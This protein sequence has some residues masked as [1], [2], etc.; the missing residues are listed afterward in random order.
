VKNVLLLALSLALAGG[1][2][3][4]AQAPAAVVEHV[5]GEFRYAIAP[6]PAFVVEH[7]IPDRWDPAVGAADDR[8]RNWLLDRQVDRRGADPVEYFASA[9]EATTTQF[10]DEAARYSIEF[11]PTYQTLQIHTLRVRRDGRWLD[12]LDPAQVSLARRE[13]D[14]ENDMS[15]GHVAALIVLPDVRPHDIVHLAYSIRGSNPIVGDQVAHS[16]PLAWSDPILDRHGRVL[17]APGTHVEVHRHDT[18]LEVA[19]R[20]SADGVEASFHLHGARAVRKADRLPSWYEPYPYVEIAASRRW[21]DVVAWALPLYP[22]DAALPPELQERLRAWRA[23][24]DRHAQVMAVLRA[25]QDEVRY[26]GIEMGDSTHKPAAPAVTWERRFG[27]CKD[28]AYLMV[29]LLRALGMEAEPALASIGNGRAVRERLPAAS[30]FDHVIVRLRLDGRTYWLD[31]TLSQQRGTLDGLDVRDYGVALPVLAGSDRLEDVVAPG[32]PENAIEVVERFVPD[33]DGKAMQL[34]V[35][36]RYFGMRAETM[37]QRLRSE[38][39]QDISARFE[40]YY[41]RAYGTLGVVTPAVATEDDAA[42]T[43]V[44]SEHYRLE[45][46]WDASGL[47]TRRLAAH[48]DALSSDV[49][50][51]DTVSRTAPIDLANPSRLTHEVR[52][53]LPPGWTLADAPESLKIEAAPV[54]YE[55]T[56]EATGNV[57]SLRHRYEIG[58]S[59]VEPD[60]L[61]DYIARVREIRNQ[62]NR[63]VNLRLPSAATRTERDRRLESLL[64]DVMAKDKGKE[65]EEARP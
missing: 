61:D 36:A 21:A 47:G 54:R 44:L 18:D 30:A 63:S 52:I 58:K 50:L 49:V 59:E 53:E 14:F 48:A 51:P 56:L 2:A 57:V 42:N 28:K 45:P 12:R 41:R 13:S 20:T 1:V 10:V 34:Y 37:R 22:A 25:L 8:W 15:D 62:L 38:R 24:G 46:G 23:L 35:E 29:T 9:Y 11:N 31:P 7:A 39:L 40:D 16:F 43:V 55:R 33:A 19:Q 27:D 64:Q 4:A 5:Q 32:K 3:R 6:V 17:F 26:F 65:K 60:Q